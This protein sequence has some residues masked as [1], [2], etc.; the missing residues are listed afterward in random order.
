MPIIASDKKIVN[1]TLATGH[2]MM[3][4]SLATATGKILTEII[5]VKAVS[6]AIDRFQM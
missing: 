1:L 5:S 6:A 4:L 3:E 2:A